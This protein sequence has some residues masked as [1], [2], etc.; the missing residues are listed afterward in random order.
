MALYDSIRRYFSRLLGMI[1]CTSGSSARSQH[2][3]VD[4]SRHNRK[5]RI[6]L[7]ASRSLSSNSSRS[8][9]S[10]S[11]PHEKQPFIAAI[12]RIEMIND[13]I[14]FIC[15]N[16]RSRSNYRHVV[17]YF[18]IRKSCRI[19]VRAAGV[20]HTRI[21]RRPSDGNRDLSLQILRSYLGDWIDVCVNIDVN[22]SHLIRIL[23]SWSTSISRY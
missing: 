10:G 13:S 8:L 6:S 18:N 3:S 12:T 2:S 1:L 15:T 4:L 11:A 9:L 22:N 7:I 16:R 14:N 20:V 5:R 21:V 19:S 17:G 23:V